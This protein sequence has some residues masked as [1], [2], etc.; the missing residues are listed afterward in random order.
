M[1]W[2]VG[3]AILFAVVVFP[4]AYGLIMDPTLMHGHPPSI[5]YVAASMMLL[6]PLAG[7]LGIACSALGWKQAA[8]FGGTAI[9][10]ATLF[11]FASVFLVATV[12][13]CYEWAQYFV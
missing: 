6:G 11:V 7:P 5:T 8:A 1:K 13:G 2:L 3:A 9:L 10:R 12:W 4:I